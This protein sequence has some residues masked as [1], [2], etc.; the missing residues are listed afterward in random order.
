[1]VIFCFVG[2]SFFLS[3]L[4]EWPV[5]PVIG[6]IHSSLVFC[7][8]WSH[9]LKLS[10]FFLCVSNSSK[11]LL[12]C[13]HVGHEFLLVRLSLKCPISASALKDKVFF[14]FR[15]NNLGKS[16]L[17]SRAWNKSFSAFL[18]FKSSSW[19]VWYCD[20]FSTVQWRFLL[21]SYF[22]VPYLGRLDDN[23][24]WKS[25]SLA[26]IEN[27]KCHW[28]GCTFLFLDLGLFIY[29]LIEYI[30]SVFNFYN[31]FFP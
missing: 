27:S 13:W 12:L 24:L 4:Y 20:M 29:N 15:Y 22:F 8:L 10:F 26:P 7:L 11:H 3:C 1:M 23:V 25:S 17:T 18:T 16:L 19:E 28:I 31:I 21:I 14:F 9:W 30:F 2:L 6:K 5:F